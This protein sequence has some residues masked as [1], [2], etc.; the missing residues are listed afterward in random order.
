ML[1]YK[2]ESY[3]LSKLHIK[4]SYFVRSSPRPISTHK[5]NTLLHLHFEPINQVVFLGSYTLR[6]GNLI[7]RLAS[8]LDAFSTYPFRT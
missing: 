6:L 2:I 8:C 4:V 1:V 5:L 3:A 7:L